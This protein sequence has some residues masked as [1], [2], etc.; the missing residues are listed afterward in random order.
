[1][2]GRADRSAAAHGRVARHDRV[3]R[4]RDDRPC[5][6]RSRAAVPGLGR[7]VAMARHRDRP[8]RDPG[9]ERL[10]G[11]C[12]GSGT[13]RRPLGAAGRCCRRD[14]GVRYRRLDAGNAGSDI[15]DPCHLTAR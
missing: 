14:P 8:L 1:M 7:D 5:R 4:H 3:H 15:R 10:R 11:L 6:A 2:R 9:N 13:S 12:G